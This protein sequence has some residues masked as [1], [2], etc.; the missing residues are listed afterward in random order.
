MVFDYFYPKKTA[1]ALPYMMIKYVLFD[2]DGTLVDSRAAVIMAFNQIAGKYGFKTITTEDLEHLHGLS[3]IDRFRFLG[4][5]LYRLPF[6]RSELLQI[7][8]RQLQEV[9]LVPG[10][11]AVIRDIRNKGL[12]TG[13]VSSNQTEIIETVLNAHDIVMDDIYCSGRFFGKDRVFRR[14]LKEQKLQP[15]EVLYICDEQRDI[16]ACK[17]VQITPVWV[18]W[19]FERA[20]VLEDVLSVCKIDEPAALLELIA[21]YNAAQ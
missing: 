5:P 14:V 2:F 18:S 4:I 15:Q 3:M 7:Y 16:D 9:S 6:L 8:H 10:M 13:I 19:G 20:A 21:G 1:A 12:R 17:K 11:D